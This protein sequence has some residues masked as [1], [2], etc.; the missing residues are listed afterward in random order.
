MYMYR[1]EADLLERK[2]AEKGLDVL[3]VKGLAMSQQ[4]ALWPRKPME[5]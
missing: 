4:C 1:L 2:S 5:S 3:V